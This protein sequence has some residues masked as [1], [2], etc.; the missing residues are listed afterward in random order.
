MLHTEM[1]V[2]KAAMDFAAEIYRITRQ[3]PS[4]ERFGLTSQIRRA[5]VSIPSNI[6]EGSG[7]ES[8]RDIRHFIV[9]ARGSLNE[10]TTQIAL[11]ER[12]CYLKPPDARALEKHAFRLRQLIA[13]TIKH[14]T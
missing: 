11:C 3:L 12:L 13:G 1:D 5:A 6:A 8:K 2:W 4:D 9:Q 7:R 10:V 14:L